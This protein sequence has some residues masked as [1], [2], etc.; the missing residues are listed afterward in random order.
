MRPLPAFSQVSAF[1]AGWI[2]LH[3]LQDRTAVVAAFSSAH[4][5]DEMLRNLPALAGIAVQGEAV[6]TPFEPGVRKRAW[7]GNCVAVGGAAVSLEPLDAVQLHLV[8][9]GVSH[10]MALFPV[11]P[12]AM[13]EAETYNLAVAAHA[14][15]IRDFQIAHYRLNQRFDEPFWDEGRDAEGP[16]SLDAKLELFASRGHVLLYDDEAFQQ[17]NW[18]SIFIGHG[19]IP[20]GYDPRVDLVPQEEHM[21]RIHNRLRTIGSLVNEMP[22]VE[23]FI[24]SMMTPRPAQAAF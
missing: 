5:D 17:P 3:P 11:L 18:A 12:D 9:V 7:I 22:S 6:I 13:P 1:R 23:Q 20:A 10:L 14:R 15:N 8:H 16:E 21:G 24:G 4:A 2:G 19:I